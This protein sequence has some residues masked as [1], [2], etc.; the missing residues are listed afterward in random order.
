MRFGFTIRR[1]NIPITRRKRRKRI[2][3]FVY[4]RWY[5]VACALPSNVSKCGGLIGEK[6]EGYARRSVL[7]QRL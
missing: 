4:L 3:R 2:F 5:V 1:M 6:R 7:Y